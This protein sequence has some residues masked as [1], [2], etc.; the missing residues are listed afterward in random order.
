[1]ILVT[2]ISG[3]GKTFTIDAAR[4]LRPD[5]AYARAS[6]ILTELGR[7]TSNLTQSIARENQQLLLQEIL[8]RH[9]QCEGR[10]IFDGHAIVETKSGPIPIWSSF[11]DRLPIAAIAT[12]IDDPVELH[13]RRALTKGKNEGSAE[14]QGLQDMEIEAS[15]AW[16]RA[17]AAQVHFIRSGQIAEFVTLLDRFRR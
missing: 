16:A 3:V 13:R 8:A 15:R 12:V 14:V 11:G 7:P 1:L 6:Q 9:I 17:S 10:L 2:G 5:F 4:R